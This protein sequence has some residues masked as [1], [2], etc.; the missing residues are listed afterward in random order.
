MECKNCYFKQS[1]M[2][3]HHLS[4]SFP[5]FFCSEYGDQLNHLFE[6]HMKKEHTKNLIHVRNKMVIDKLIHSLKLKFDENAIKNGWCTW[7]INFDPVWVTNC[8]INEFLIGTTFY[9]NFI[10]SRQIN[11][12][13]NTEK[14]E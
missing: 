11:E 4:C 9:D 7:P 10:F 6:Q 2:M 12:F 13:M 1:I 8:E 5:S 3:T 14:K